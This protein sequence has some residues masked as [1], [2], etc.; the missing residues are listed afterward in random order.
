[1]SEAFG[2]SAGDE[3][4]EIE[5]EST[6]DDSFAGPTDAD[7]EQAEARIVDEVEE[8]EDDFENTG[9][10]EPVDPID[11]EI[12]DTTDEMGDWEPLDEDDL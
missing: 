12:E 3:Q 4:S 6:G 1:M 5:I 7:Y 2:D 10:E 8:S 11:E 9:F